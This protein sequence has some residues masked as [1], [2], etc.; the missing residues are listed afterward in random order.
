MPRRPRGPGREAAVSTTGGNVS[1]PIPDASAGI[2]A[3]RLTPRIATLSP[4]P[5][6]EGVLLRESGKR[7]VFLSLPYP[8]KRVRDRGDQ[9]EP[10]GA[11]KNLRRVH[12]ERQ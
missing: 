1:Q 5:S 11:E 6:T 12:A 4:K 2:V 7:Y 10:A 8:R 9:R 3:H